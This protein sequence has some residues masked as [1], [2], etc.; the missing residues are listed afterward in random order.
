MWSYNTV[1]SVVRKK[2]E[3]KTMNDANE[4]DTEKMRYLALRHPEKGF[5]ELQQATEQ[6]PTAE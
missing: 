2:T 5:A 6:F 4:N 1:P 3:T